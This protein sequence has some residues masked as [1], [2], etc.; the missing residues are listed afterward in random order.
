MTKFCL[1]QTDCESRF[2]TL[3]VAERDHRI[4]SHRAATFAAAP[5]SI[6]GPSFTYVFNESGL[7]ALRGRRVN[8][9]L[10]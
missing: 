4:K 1:A 8:A 10:F 5:F 3:F 7:S 6:L 9:C 2:M